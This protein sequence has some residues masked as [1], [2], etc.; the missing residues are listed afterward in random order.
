MWLEY[1]TSS[2]WSTGLTNE[3][4]RMTSDVTDAAAAAAEFT[5]TLHYVIR[6]S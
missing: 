5:I 3:A 6:V 4:P 2:D 1:R